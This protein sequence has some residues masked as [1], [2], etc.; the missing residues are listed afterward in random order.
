MGLFRRSANAKAVKELQAK[1]DLG[2]SLEFD[3]SDVH[4]AAVL[5]KTFLRELSAP[6]LTYQLY[7]SILHFSDL[8]KSSQLSY[9]Q[10]LVI[11]K[12]PDQNYVVLKYLVEFL[13]LV[14]DRCDMN[15]M[16][17]A[18]L[19]VVF[20]PNL[21]WPHDKTMTLTSIGPIN[22]FTEYLFSNMH[23]VFII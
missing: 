11:K 14:V 7:D 8:P 23:Q 9:C 4:I 15:K 13:S 21:A 6:L 2:V 5:L 20:G 12:L 3:K 16:T 10:D 18:N 1:V 19:A 22:A 17:A